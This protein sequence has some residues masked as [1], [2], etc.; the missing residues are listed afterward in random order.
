MRR[1]PWPSWYTPPAAKSQWRNRI[2]PDTVVRAA[3]GFFS[4][5]LT[6]FMSANKC[7]ANSDARCAS[8]YVLHRR[9]PDLSWQ[10]IA[11]KV[12]RKDHSTVIHAYKRA[13]HKIAKSPEF[14]EIILKL[15]SVE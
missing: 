15:E 3:C 4:I 13:E 8:V 2:S 6:D 12:W 1:L 14:A 7:A 5:S 11:R 9:R 10:Q